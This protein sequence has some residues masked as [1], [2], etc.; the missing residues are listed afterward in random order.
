MASDILN[1]LKVAILIT[2]GFEQ[3]EMTEPRKALDQAGAETRIVS[4]KDG[5][6]KAWNFTEW[7]DQFPVDVPLN[8]A[9][10]DDYDALL[11][12]GGVINPD[13]LRTIPEAVAYAKSFFEAGKPVAS[14]CHGPWTIIEAGAARGRRLTSWPSLQTDLRNAGADWVDEQ[15]VVDGNLVTSRKPDDIPAFNAEVVKLFTS[16]CRQARQ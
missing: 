4:P 15:V 12:P 13:T 6:V 11:L 2:D 14:I 8:G 5:K 9:R 1:G 3:V 7:G 16:A 10:P